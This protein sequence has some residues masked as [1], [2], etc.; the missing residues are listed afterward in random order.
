[1]PLT[2]SF[3][4]AIKTFT[5]VTDN[6]TE[7]TSTDINPV[8]A[9]ITSIETELGANPAGTATDVVTRL[10]KA[11]AGDGSLKFATGSELTISSGVI[12]PTQNWHIIDTQGDAATDD[13]D[14]IGSSDTED[15]FILFLRQANDARD[16]TIKHGTGNIKCPG[17]VDIVLTD[18]YQIVIMIYDATLEK[19]IATVSSVNAGLLNGANIWSA[20]N[21]FSKSL[22]FAYTSVAAATVLDSTYYFVDVDCTAAGKTITLPTAVGI[23]GREYIIRKLDASANIVTIDGDG[24]ETINGSLTKTLVEQYDTTILFSNG[25]NWM[26]LA[27]GGGGGASSDLITHTHTASTDG[28]LIRL[29]TI[30]VPTDSTGNDASTDTHGLLPKLSGTGTEF[31]SGLGTWATPAGGSSTDLIEHNHSSSD[32]GG[33]LRLDTISAPTDV[34][35]L[36][37]TTDAHGLFPKLSGS[38]DQYVNGKGEWATVTGG[39]GASSDLVVHGHTGPADGG[40]IKL[41][42]LQPP[43]DTTDLDATVAMHGLLPKL[44]A[45]TAHFLNGYGAFTPITDAQN[46]Y[47]GAVRLVDSSDLISGTTD[48]FSYIKAISVDNFIALMNSATTDFDANIT[49]HGFLPKLSGVNTEY[50]SGSGSFS[51]PAGGSGGWKYPCNGRL[52]LVNQTPITTSDYATTDAQILYFSAFYG[53]EISLHDGSTDTTAWTIYT[54]PSTDLMLNISTTDYSTSDNFDIWVYP[55]S[56][57]IPAMSSTKWTDNTTRGT[58]LE[59][60]SGIYCKTGATQYRYVG[61]IRMVLDGQSEKSRSK[62]FIYNCYNKLSQSGWN[63]FTSNQTFAGPSWT[64]INTEIRIGFVIGL[65]ETISASA[66]IIGYTEASL[67]ADMRCAFG[68]DGT[69]PEDGIAYGQ[70]SSVLQPVIPISLSNR[71]SNLSPGYH[72]LTLLGYTGSSSDTSTVLGASTVFRTQINIEYNG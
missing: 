44:G 59:T 51:T 35:T 66:N 9:E 34:T 37:S 26:E 48:G 30:A 3:P 70:A 42:D 13:L 7:M 2:P 61:T 24:A 33:I 67:L 20:V 28:G 62:L 58:A 21:S 25:A 68:Y 45:N 23:N 36:N 56:D 16:I 12:T 40:A 47:N 38:S 31:M 14:T 1:M 65:P 71:K 10:A 49:T 29:D 54:I 43:D 22:N 5:E 53:D 46:N 60:V 8:Y 4:G 69:V 19:W 41:D 50:L 64:E 18:T 15:G 72:Y 6:V 55:T 57:S 11:L 52:T 32:T 63:V 27:T 39:G 17:S